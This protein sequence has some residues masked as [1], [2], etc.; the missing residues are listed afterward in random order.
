MGEVTR[1]YGSLLDL[2]LNCE[3]IVEFQLLYYV[4]R[5]KN[6]DHLCDTGYTEH[7]QTM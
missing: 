2:F 4:G 1:R 3:M 6:N 5:N 7:Q